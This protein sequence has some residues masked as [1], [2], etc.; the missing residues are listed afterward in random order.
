MTLRRHASLEARQWAHFLTK[1]LWTFLPD[2]RLLPL[3]MCTALRTSSRC[4]QN[5]AL[6]GED[7]KALQFRPL[8]SKECHPQPAKWIL[9]GAMYVGWGGHVEEWPSLGGLQRPTVPVQGKPS[10]SGWDAGPEGYGGAASWD[11]EP[12][13]KSWTDPSDA[14]QETQRSTKNAPPEQPNEWGPENKGN[15]WLAV[16]SPQQQSDWPS[17]PAKQEAQGW[18]PVKQEADRQGSW[19]DWGKST[20]QPSGWDEPETSGQQQQSQHPAAPSSG[21]GDVDHAQ[22]GWGS[23]I[24]QHRNT[25]ASNN[26]GFKGWGE[27]NPTAVGDTPPNFRQSSAVRRNLASDT[28]NNWLGGASSSVKPDAGRLGAY[29]RPRPSQEADQWQAM[30]SRGARPGRSQGRYAHQQQQQG[31]AHSQHAQQVFPHPIQASR[32]H[33]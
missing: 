25:P 8:S 11:S 27:N 22:A 10:S 15:D 4:L 20:Q 24:Q 16:K 30:N 18:G 33:P 12:A 3:L 28:S 7:R 29:D 19:G 31:P 32:S 5:Q 9:V 26:S 23:P 1:A 21:W 6:P 13:G 14:R 17:L 2:C